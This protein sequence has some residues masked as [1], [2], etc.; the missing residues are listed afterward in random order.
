LI[1]ISGSKDAL[2]P[3]CGLPIAQYF[4]ALKIKWLIDNEPKIAEKLKNGSALAG[5]VD[6]WLVWK[7]IF[8]SFLLQFFHQNF[9]L[10]NPK[11]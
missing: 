6:S 9:A 8:F 3:Q 10:K 7:V 1:D 11:I 2:R 5:T 4:S